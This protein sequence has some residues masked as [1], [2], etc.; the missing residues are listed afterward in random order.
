MLNPNE[1]VRYIVKVEVYPELEPMTDEFD[2]DRDSLVELQDMLDE[3][4]ESGEDA[5]EEIYQ[6]KQYDL[7][8]DCC[9]QYVKNPV[10]P[11]PAVQFGFSNN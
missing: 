4:A 11:E 1:D 9:R 5:F 6:K 10:G 8:A 2:D 7:C 3:L